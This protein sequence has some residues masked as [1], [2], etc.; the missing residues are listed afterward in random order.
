MLDSK[1]KSLDNKIVFVNLSE[2]I[3]PNFKINKSKEYVLWGDDNLWPLYLQQLLSKSAIHNS[4]FR[5]KVKMTYGNGLFIANE[6]DLTSQQVNKINKFFSEINPTLTKNEIIQRS[7]YDLQLYGGFTWQII[8]SKDKSR[9]VNINP[10][11]MADIRVGK[12]DNGQ[13][14]EFYYSADWADLK[15]NPYEIYPAFDMSNPGGTQILYVRNY[16][17][18]SPYYPIENY[19]GGLNYINVDYYISNY[20]VNNLRN[21]LTPTIIISIPGAEP[22]QEEIDS[23]YKR[24]KKLY[25]STDNAGKFI[26]MFPDDIKNKIDVQPINLTDADKQFMMLNELTTQGII[27]AHNVTSPMLFGVKTE[28]QLGGRN[29]IITQSELFYNDVISHDQQ[30]IESALEKILIYNSLEFANVQI[31]RSTSVKFMFGETELAKIT[32][33]NERR[34]MIDLPDVE[35]GNNPPTGI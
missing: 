6:N 5:R 8:Y 13:I 11:D 24:I 20:H 2:Q 16:D 35:N 29:E 22:T 34:R 31:K 30:L 25:S 19:R 9:I 21:G 3:A 10:I 17:S 18:G 7:S 4:I 27:M 28:G 33:V 26:L 1:L 32:T 23:I 14:K 12:L 15:N